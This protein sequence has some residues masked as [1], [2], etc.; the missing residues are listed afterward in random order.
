MNKIILFLG[1][2]V[3]LILLPNLVNA[4]DNIGLISKL[5]INDQKSCYSSEETIPQIYTEDEILFRI[6]I[7][8]AKYN[9]ICFEGFSYSYRFDKTDIGYVQNLW[10]SDSVQLKSCLPK[11]EKVILYFP[12][13][14]YPSEKD[15]RRGDWKIF[16]I[17][18]SLTNLRCYKDMT[19][20]KGD[21]QSG[22][23]NKRIVSND[24][25]FNVMKEGVDT[26]QTGLRTQTIE[27][28][29]GWAKWIVGVLAVF[30]LG[31]IT[32]AKKYRTLWI[33]IFIILAIIEFLLFVF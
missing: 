14:E 13:L 31:L 29:K 33:I 32:L 5:C 9:W 7:I 22:D 24:V 27:K 12:L 21:C 17:S 2:V 1:F 11:N 20:E 16:D 18:T 15:K 3:L 19:L 26:S 23:N 25:K 6:E 8:N 30:F 28:I 4:S 10:N